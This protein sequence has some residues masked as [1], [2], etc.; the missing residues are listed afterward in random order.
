MFVPRLYV[1][2][3]STTSLLWIIT[4]SVNLIFCAF[5]QGIC[6]S[7]LNNY[8]CVDHLLVCNLSN[9]PCICVR[10]SKLVVCFQF[11]RAPRTMNNPH[12]LYLSI[13]DSATTHTKMSLDVTIDCIMMSS[14]DGDLYSQYGNKIERSKYLKQL[15]FLNTIPYLYRSCPSQDQDQKRITSTSCY[16]CPKSIGDDY[17]TY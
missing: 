1:E 7:I 2:R 11:S 9:Q 15:I 10:V 4:I 6:N 17:S 14:K 3:L 16:L 5:T 13:D 8:W 12:L